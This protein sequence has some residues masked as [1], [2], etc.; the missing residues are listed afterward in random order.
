[1][2]QSSIALL[3][4]EIF[5][6][7]AKIILSVF[8]SSDIGS[9]DPSSYAEMHTSVFIFYA[10]VYCKKIMPPFCVFLRHKNANLLFW[11]FVFNYVERKK[12]R[13]I[14]YFRLYFFHSKNKELF[15]YLQSEWLN[16]C[17][18]GLYL[19]QTNGLK[20]WRDSKSNN[21]WPTKQKGK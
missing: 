11:L 8:W 5:F 20:S 19:K 9:T 1:M 18:I 14:D 15:Q 13:E 10:F 3:N 2:K 12:F 4:L 21:V 7:F 16:A 6:P 17:F